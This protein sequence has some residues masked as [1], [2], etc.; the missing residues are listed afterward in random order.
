MIQKLQI[1]LMKQTTPYAVSDS[2]DDLIS[3]SK[4][5]SKDLLKWFDDNLMK[6]NPDKCHLLVRSC[7]KG[8][9]GNKWL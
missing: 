9:N 4:K 7:K 5:S 1:M 6:Y 8:K 2:I 3:F